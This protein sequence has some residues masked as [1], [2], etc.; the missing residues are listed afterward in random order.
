MPVFLKATKKNRAEPLVIIT[1]PTR[2]I[3][4]SLLH[5]LPLPL[6]YTITSVGISSA[7]SLTV[8]GGGALP[9]GERQ[10]DESLASGGILSLAS[11]GGTFYRARTASKLGNGNGGGTGTRSSGPKGRGDVQSGPRAYPRV[12][13]SFLDVNNG[14]R[15]CP[16]FC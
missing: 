13:S 9:T 6:P 11:S 15:W 14:E 16:L 4:F 12:A 10:H 2:N 1:Q 3:S 5:S 8:S 7:L